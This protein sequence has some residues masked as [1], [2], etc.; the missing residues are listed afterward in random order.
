MDRGDGMKKSA[1]FYI[2]LASVLWGTS[3]LFAHYLRPFGFTSVQMTLMRGAVSMIIMVGFVLIK[4]RK[5]LLVSKKEILLLLG[6]GV[7]LFGTATA[8]YASMEASSVS[9][10]VVLMYTAPVFVLIYSVLFLGEKLNLIKGGAI[11]LMLVGCALVSGIVGGME[12]SLLGI[13]FGMISGIS[14]SAYN[15]FTKILTMHKV[16]AV[17]VTSYNFIIITVLGLITAKPLAM[18]ECA[19]KEPVITIPLMVGIGICTCIL[20]Y[21]FYTL[22]LK[23]T[24][25]G[26][27]SSLGIIE[28]LSATIFS[29]CFLGEALTVPLIIGMILICGAVV[30]LAKQK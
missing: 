16:P 24:P 6:S 12:F 28:P 9:T 13:I 20:P 1:F 17:T 19:T 15:I 2:V 4:D 8:Y 29:V 23:D 5:W 11:L 22:G 30:A 27:A 14:Y 26:I 10:A 3:G 25:A 21:F 7:S 18:V